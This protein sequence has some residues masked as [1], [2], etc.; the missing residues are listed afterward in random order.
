[1]AAS[2][3]L[4]IDQGSD[5]SAEIDLIQ[6]NGEPMNLD[7]AT[8]AS[9]FRRSYY[10][11]TSHSLTASI[12]DS[13]N[14]IVR[15]QLSANVSSNIRPGRYVYDVEVSTPSGKFRALEGLINLY[16]EVTK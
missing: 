9:Q 3:N 15:L 2:T 6:D 11:A 5:F 14:G 8:V 13:A 16:P 10:S 12:L 1:M 7:S 4:Y